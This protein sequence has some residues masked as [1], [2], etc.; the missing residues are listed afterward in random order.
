M[1]NEQFSGQLRQHLLGAANERLAEGQL[2]SIVDR[3]AVTPQRPTLVARLPWL[4]G[5]LGSSP[6]SELRWAV[7]IALALVGLTVAGA[8]LVGG[9]GPRGRGFEGTWTAIDAG[10]GSTQLLLVGAGSTPAVRYVDELSSGN[11]CRDRGVTVFIANGTGAVTGN[12]LEVT[13]PGGGACGRDATTISDRP[14]TYDESTDTLIDGS[15]TTWTR[16]ADDAVVPTPE[17]TTDITPLTPSCSPN[18]SEFDAT[19]TYTAP[20]GSM[21]LTVSVPAT[22]ATPWIGNRDRFRLIQASCTD[23]SGP[24]AIEAGEVVLVRNDA[25][26]GRAVQTLDDAIA[27]VSAST[28]IDVVAKTDVTLGGHPGTRFDIF[29]HEDA[30][31]CTDGVVDGVALEPGV[32]LRLYLIDVDGKFLALALYGYPLWSPAVRATVDEILAS[33]KTDAPAAAEASPTNAPPNGQCVVFDGPGSY[34]ATAGPLSLT[35]DV[36]ATTAD[37]WHGLRDGFDLYAAPCIFGGARLQ[38]STVDVV[39]PDACGRPGTAVTVDTPAEAITALTAMTGVEVSAPADVTIG[40]YPG[41]KFEITVPA[42]YVATACSDGAVVVADGST[43]LDTGA[44]VTTLY[45]LDVDGTTLAL[46]IFG[47]EDGDTAVIAQ[48]DEVL[49]SMQISR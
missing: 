1:T 8:I 31:A 44:G 23:W 40:G 37:P 4:H 35:V 20:A 39:Y 49:A 32:N 43:N 16:T 45:V 34:T 30:T 41:T 21:S 10:D 6:A 48:F 5:Q 28:A 9:I 2:A 33:L 3:I 26:D 38:G 24:G 27:A 22:A 25:C 18:R 42:D 13:W 17:P 12:R 36:P 15:A 47:V 7:L 46:A 19:V 29:V 14:Y 11:A